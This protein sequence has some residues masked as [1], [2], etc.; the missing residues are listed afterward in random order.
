MFRSLLLVLGLIALSHAQD[1]T[2]ED[3][4]NLEDHYNGDCTDENGPL[5]C[6]VCDLEGA[7]NTLLLHIYFHV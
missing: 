6:E 4:W 2:L 7:V 5:T 1:S 3:E